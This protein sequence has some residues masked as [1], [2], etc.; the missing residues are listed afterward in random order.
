MAENFLVDNR[1]FTATSNFEIRWCLPD[2]QK[3]QLGVGDKLFVLVSLQSTNI[4]FQ[5][6][7]TKQVGSFG[8]DLGF[9]LSTSE[10]GIIRNAELDEKTRIKLDILNRKDTNM[11]QH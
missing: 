7:G 11:K 9:P 3:I 4:N 6:G 10:Q 5:T 2:G 1:N 8:W